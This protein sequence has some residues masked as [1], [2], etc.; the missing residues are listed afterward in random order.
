MTDQGE[1]RSSERRG[2]K[3]G[4]GVRRVLWATGIAVAATAVMIGVTLPRD[5]SGNDQS[6]RTGASGRTNPSATGGSGSGQGGAVVENSAPKG[7][8]TTGRGPLTKADVDRARDIALGP[9]PWRK[10]RTVEGKGGPEYLD[11]DLADEAEP[12]ENG[13]RRVEVYFYD[14]GDD[15]LV[16]KTVNLT[17]GKV[18]RTDSATGTQLPPS[19]DE[20][21][22]AAELLIKSPLGEG[23][24][25]DFKAAAN[26]TA[27]TGSS[28]L[29]LRGITYSTAEQ[30]G[31]ASLAK[32]GK[33]RCVRLF[34][35][36]KNGP[37]IDTTNLVVD[38]SD[39]TVGR[40]D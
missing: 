24:R 29:R 27:L 35:Q 2:G 14:Y 11:T 16:K 38:L 6:G 8:V 33:H 21:T 1:G 34:T 19:V 37:W 25:K 4:P 10:A 15:T 30:S 5:A 40:I 32:C 23:L 20:T 36:V 13:T 18:E 31:P 28:Q 9:A 12:Q 22:K 17:T 39:R 3:A 26:G 7:E